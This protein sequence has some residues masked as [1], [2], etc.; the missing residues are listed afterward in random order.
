MTRPGWLSAKTGGKFPPWAFTDPELNRELATA[1]GE[2]LTALRAE[3]DSRADIRARLRNA[4][5]ADDD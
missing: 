4:P 1:T 3:R 5:V 2:Q